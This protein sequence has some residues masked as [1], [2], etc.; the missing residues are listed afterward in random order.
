MWFNLKYLSHFLFSSFSHFFFHFFPPFRWHILV[1]IK[2]ISSSLSL[3][4]EKTLPTLPSKMMFNKMHVQPESV[5]REK[6]KSN[7]SPLKIFPPEFSCV[8]EHY[9]LISSFSSTKIPKSFP[10]GL[11][12]IGSFPS[13]YRYWGLPPPTCRTLEL[14]L[15][16]LNLMTFPLTHFLSM[17]TSLW[18]AACPSAMST[19]PL[20]MVQKS[21]CFHKLGLFLK[22]SASRHIRGIIEQSLVFPKADFEILGF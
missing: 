1:L 5:L 19:M 18:M 4:K 9:R 22:V 17:S 10:A 3:T 11:F 2:P 15:A 12:S 16:L 6:K 20:S 13:L 14:A 21:L 8:N 7:F